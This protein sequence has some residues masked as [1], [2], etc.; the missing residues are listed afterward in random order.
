MLSTTNGINHTYCEIRRHY[1]LQL[2]KNWF[3]Y[4]INNNL[5]KYSS[6]FLAN[7]PFSVMTL[8]V[9]LF[10]IFGYLSLKVLEYN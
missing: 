9:S 3:N 4:S 8:Q 6:L 1:L 2:A 7:V 10:H 5:S